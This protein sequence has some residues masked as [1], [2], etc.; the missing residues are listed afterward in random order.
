MHRA[1]LYLLSVFILQNWR[2]FVVELWCVFDCVCSLHP[3]HLSDFCRFISCNHTYFKMPSC[4]FCSRP[5]ANQGNLNRHMQEFHQKDI[6]ESK[7]QP[8]PL[9][10]LTLKCHLCDVR[11]HDRSDFISHLNKDHQFELVI[12]SKTFDT[13]QGVYSFQIE[14]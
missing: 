7:Q 13:I 11:F 10:K 14:I 5:F 2:Q 12:K 6:L 9:K 8:F 4:D 3:S 1:G